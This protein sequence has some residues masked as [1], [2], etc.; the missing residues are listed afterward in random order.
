MATGTIIPIAK[1]NRMEALTSCQHFAVSVPVMRPCISIVPRRRA[2]TMVEAH[3]DPIQQPAP[4]VFGTECKH[5]RRNTMGGPFPM[6]E[7]FPC[8][9][10][11]AGR[12]CNEPDASGARYYESTWPRHPIGWPTD[13]DDLSVMPLAHHHRGANGMKASDLMF[14]GRHGLLRRRP[15]I[16]ESAD[17][18]LPVTVRLVGA[19]YSPTCRDKW[20]GRARP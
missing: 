14:R 8:R 11:V 4:M 18:P 20:P 13:R 7:D 5:I 19:T 6:D 1:S 2:S 17:M 15:T 16:S 10:V 3:G 9:A 12:A